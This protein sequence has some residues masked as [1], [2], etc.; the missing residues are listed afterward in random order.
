MTDE[1]L[2]YKLEPDGCWHDIISNPDG[3]T[4]GKCKKCGRLFHAIHLSD[5]NPDEF[6]PDFTTWEGFGWLWER[7]IEKDWWEKFTM[8]I[9]KKDVYP[10]DWSWA[11]NGYAIHQ[12]LINPTRFRDA[13]KEYFERGEGK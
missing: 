1:E 6:N 7:C 2:F 4:L 13:L 5:W 10:I 9:Y 12:Y 11:M 3:T 8:F